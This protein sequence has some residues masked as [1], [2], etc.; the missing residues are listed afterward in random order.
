MGC[1]LKIGVTGDSACLISTSQHQL[2]LLQRVG[3][4][5]VRRSH[6]SGTAWPDP[7]AQF[8]CCPGE[9]HPSSF[10]P[11]SD[12][13]A[14]LQLCRSPSGNCLGAG[15]REQQ[16]SCCQTLSRWF[17]PHLDKA[18]STGLTWEA[19]QLC[20]HILSVT[21]GFSCAAVPRDKERGQHVGWLSA[22]NTL[23]PAQV[24]RD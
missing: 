5:G 7:G 4:S 23:M 16:P 13:A 9:W 19:K 17:H 6:L 1:G 11:S 10:P 20:E 12:R 21:A 22:W 24:C 2:V 14:L 8:Q 3:R 15:R 18:L